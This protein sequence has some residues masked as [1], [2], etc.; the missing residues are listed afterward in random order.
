MKSIYDN[1]YS[2]LLESPDILTYIKH[3]DAYAAHI[4]YIRHDLDHMTSVAKRSSELLLALGYDARYAELVK[5][6]A[7]LHDIGNLVNRIEHAQSSALMAFSLLLNRSMDPEEIAVICTAIGNHDEH[8]GVPVN[9]AAAALILADKT[10]V[11]HSRAR[12]QDTPPAYEDIHNRVNYAVTENTFQLLSNEKELHFRVVLDPSC[13][14]P[15]DFMQI[16]TERMKLSR[17]AAQ[18]LG[19]TFRLW[20]NDAE[21]TVY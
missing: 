17:L 3:A 9:P 19:L 12:Q 5:I 7:L 16:Y 4:G 21:I 2:S 18:T 6:A 14:V 13:A 10:D 15:E 8:T 11:R 20:L 1:T